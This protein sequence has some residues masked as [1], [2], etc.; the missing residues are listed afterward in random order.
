M[1]QHTTNLPV[2]KVQLVAHALA[3]NVSHD[4]MLLSI[5]YSF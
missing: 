3:L 5:Q 1:R 4:Y 2:H